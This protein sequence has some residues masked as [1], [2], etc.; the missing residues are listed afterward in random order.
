M[1]HQGISLALRVI[2]SPFAPVV[3]QN[4]KWESPIGLNFAAT[5]GDSFVKVARSHSGRASLSHQ[6]MQPSPPAVKN[7]FWL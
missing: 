6:A 4:V 5:M 3:A 2:V 7:V 1:V